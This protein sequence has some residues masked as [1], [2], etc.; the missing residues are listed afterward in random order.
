MKELDEIIDNVRLGLNTSND[1]TV[2]FENLTEKNIKYK[3]QKA[4]S[5]VAKSIGV[6]TS[7]GREGFSCNAQKDL[8][9]RI[10]DGCD[11][12]AK[13]LYA[14]I[15]AYLGIPESDVVSKANVT[16][17][18]KILYNSESGKPL[19][20][21][22][23]ERLAKALKKYLNRHRGSGERYV[24]YADALGRVLAR[25]EAENPKGNTRKQR[26]DDIRLHGMTFNTICDKPEKVFSF[27]T[28]T[29]ERVELAK[30]SA[31]LKIVEI[32]DVAVDRIQSVIVDGIAKR[33]SKAAV[34]Q[35]LLRVCGKLNRDWQR[36]ADTEV[37]NNLNRA[38]IN[39]TV[40]LSDGGKVY[41]RRVEVVDGRTCAY[42]KRMNGKIALYSSMPMT[43]DKINDDYAELAIW[44]GKEWDGKNGVACTGVFHPSCRGLWVK[45]NPESLKKIDN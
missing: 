10:L 14:F 26:L 7:S 8:T 32:D 3:F 18:G 24:T 37:Q 38:Y 34:S 11:K 29:K 15:C 27:D 6:S 31:G 30:M 35:D 25:L 9:E 16:Y 22:D 5:L 33:K 23:V 21:A 12:K 1:W 13:G 40:R 36:I 44:D 2:R 19:S 45:C 20:K 28:M 17:H 43:E 39:E 4:Y 41:F 42:C